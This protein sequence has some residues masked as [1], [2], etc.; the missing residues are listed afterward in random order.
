[1]IVWLILGRSTVWTKAL[2]IA[3]AFAASVVG[4]VLSRVLAPT[5]TSVY[6]PWLPSLS[7]MSGY[8]GGNLSRAGPIGQVGLTGVVVGALTLYAWSRYRRRHVT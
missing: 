7:D 3:G 2:M 8:F 4:V 6:N 1:M 5:A